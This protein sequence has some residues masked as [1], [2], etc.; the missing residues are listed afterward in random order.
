MDI[1]WDVMLPEEYINKQWEKEERK[2]INKP[3]VYSPLKPKCP[4]CNKRVT[5][6]DV[7][8]EMIFKFDKKSITYV[9]YAPICKECGSEVKLTS[10]DEYNKKIADKIYRQTFDIITVD[11][12]KELLEML[13]TNHY[14]LSFY[15]EWGTDTI[16]RYLKGTI[17]SKR[18]SD[19]LKNLLYNP[20]KSMEW[21][22]EKNEV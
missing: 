12:I 4:R 3:R 14:T 8:K 19:I 20:E 21:I 22:K 17:P 18:F 10:Y 13:K 6:F 9:G 7:D 16:G 2:Q 1:L 15:L 11:E 5:Y